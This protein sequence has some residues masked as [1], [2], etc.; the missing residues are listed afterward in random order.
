MPENE[1]KQ[2]KTWHIHGSLATETPLKDISYDIFVPFAT[3]EFI[4]DFYTEQAYFIILTSRFTR[5]NRVYFT[6]K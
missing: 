2:Q 3:D 1:I 6:I 5:M 4:S